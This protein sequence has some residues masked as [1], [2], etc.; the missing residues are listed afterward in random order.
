MRDDV[1]QVRSVG[2]NFY[3]LRDGKGLY[4][5]DGGFIGGRHR[6]R[7]ALRSQ[8]WERLPILGILV[9]HGHLDHILNVSRI[10]AETGAWIA[11]P[12]LDAAHYAGHPS[13]QGAAR[14]TGCLEAIG[15]PALGFHAF[16]PSRLLDDGDELDVWHGLTVV[17]LPGHTAGHSGFYCSRLRLLFCADLFASFGHLT[18]FP[19]TILNMDSRQVLRSAAKALELNLQ[20]VLPNHADGASPE[21]HLE[22]LRKLFYHHRAEEYADA[23]SHEERFK[24]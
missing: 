6:L 23:A 9:T 22:R 11:A 7:Q 4:L 2:V 10:A 21:T 19:P 5:I 14:V 3:V 1:L 20:G 18:H 16:T 15:R 24:P 8:G 17:H 13:Y 12:R